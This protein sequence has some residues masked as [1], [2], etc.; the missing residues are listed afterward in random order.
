MVMDM[1]FANQSLAVEYLY[2]NVKSM[3][4]KVYTVPDSI[5]AR[6]AALK[7]KSMKVSVDKLTPEQVKYLASWQTGT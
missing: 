1:S 7:L 5:D 3:E 6:I 4:K 2:K